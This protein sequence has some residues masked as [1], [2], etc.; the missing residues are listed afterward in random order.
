MPNPTAAMLVIGDEILSG[1]TRDINLHVLSGKLADAGIDLREAR[2]VPDDTAVI[3]A[4]VNTL[5]AGHDHLFTCGG[6]GPTHDDITSDA[7]AQAF[8]VPIAIRDDALR[9]LTSVYPGGSADL[10]GPRLRMARVPKG[11][12]LIENPISGAPGYSIGNVHVMAG[13]PLVFEAML[14]GLLVRIGGG[15][16]L[17]SNSFRI[18]RP[19][20]E[21]AAALGE[22]AEAF[23]AVAIGS[24]PFFADGLPGCNVVVRGTDGDLVKQAGDRVQGLVPPTKS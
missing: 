9:A 10:N 5:R 12:R 23:P 8:G 17:I 13:V 24:Y 14:D 3:A 4:S 18:H 15:T 21:L 16:P 6:I 19:E 2:I 7:I 20:G 11:A 22:I 1:R